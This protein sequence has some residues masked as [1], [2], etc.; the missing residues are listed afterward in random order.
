MNAPLSCIPLLNF[1]EVIYMIIIEMSISVLQYKMAVQERQCV[2]PWVSGKTP[3]V[4]SPI[5]TLI[6]TN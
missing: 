5:N 1:D 2:L 3:W 4:S 6:I